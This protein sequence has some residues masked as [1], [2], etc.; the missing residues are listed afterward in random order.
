MKKAFWAVVA[1]AFA[2]CLGACSVDDPS[3]DFLGDNSDVTGFS[4]TTTTTPA[5]D[6]S[7]SKPDNS[8]SDTESKPDD[9]LPSQEQN[10]AE[11][12]IYNYMVNELG[13]GEDYDD[14]LILRCENASIPDGV[15]TDRFDARFIAENT[16][17]YEQYCEIMNIYQVYTDAQMLEPNIYIKKDVRYPDLEA[18][19]E[20]FLSVMHESNLAAFEKRFDFYDGCIQAEHRNAEDGRAYTEYITNDI[21]IEGDTAYATIAYKR[22]SDNGS[23]YFTSEKLTDKALSLITYEYE[24]RTYEFKKDDSGNWKMVTPP[25]WFEM[26]YDIY[27]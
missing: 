18:F 7:D 21:K 16:A 14:Y 9:I 15:I 23:Y 3:S 11:E 27:S 5:S 2:I 24:N 17:S 8:V 6:I 25:N 1:M 13:L 10:G 22:Q 4:D 26:Y 12:N 19:K 20:A